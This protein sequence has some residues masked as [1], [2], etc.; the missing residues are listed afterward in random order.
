LADGARAAQGLAPHP[1]H[2]GQGFRAAGRDRPAQR[3]CLVHP[4]RSDRSPAGEVR[5]HQYAPH[6][7]GAPI[8]LAAAAAAGGFGLIIPARPIAPSTGTRKT[9][10]LRSVEP[11]LADILR[12]DDPRAQRFRRE[13]RRLNALVMAD[14]AM[15]RA[16]VRHGGRAGPRVL[17]DLGSGDGTFMLRVARRLA[18]R[19]RDITAI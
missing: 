9:F 14:R 1:D 16:L 7:P 11:E 19:W 5:R 3:R 8:V 6:W 4:R 2:P 18:P 13:L 10:L 15:A 12:A 17:I